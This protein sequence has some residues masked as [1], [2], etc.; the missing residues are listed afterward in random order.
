MCVAN[1]LIRRVL[2]AAGLAASCAAGPA[3]ALTF[4]Y[5]FTAGTPVVAQNAFIAAGDLWSAVLSDPITVRLTV[6]TAAL[7]GSVLGQAS[8]A[9]VAFSYGTVRDALVADASSAND[10]LA[11]SSLPLGSVPLLINRTSQN[12]N[13]ATPYLDNN[14]SDNNTVIELSTANA[15]ALGLPVNLGVLSGCVT[16]CDGFIRFNSSF[17]FDYDR[18]NGVTSNQFDFIGIAAHE[19][20][21]VLGFLSGVDLLDGNPGLSE[22]QFRLMPL[23]LYRYSSG[24][25]AQ[26][27][28]DF[29]A[30]T[31][32]KYFSING[33]AAS[34]INFATGVAFGD[35][36]QASHWKDGLGQVIMDPTSAPGEFLAIG[37]NDRTAFDVI[38]WNLT[39]VPE[40]GKP[41]MLALGLAVLAIGVRRR[42]KAG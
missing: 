24:S 25:A 33:G 8:S 29:T 20:G 23:D 18:S 4:D 38:G 27:A 1:P 22:D 35:G 2:G 3:G 13:S 12:S 5:S 32:T 15:A 31:A 9:Q 6:G 30:S 19:I 34:G 28:V 14:A 42:H 26:G 11:V 7:G 21:H 16:L 10:L 36:R 40:P 41:V 39:P 17:N 37:P